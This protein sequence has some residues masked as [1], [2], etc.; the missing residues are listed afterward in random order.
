MKKYDV[1]IIGG[2]ITGLTA[3]FRLQRG[4]KSVLVVEKTDRVGGQIR[5]HSE[6]GFTFESGPNTSVLSN[7]EIVELFEDLSP[8]V[9]LQTANPAAQRRLIWKGR[10]FH[11]LPSGL[12]SAITTPLFTLS[13]KFR[14][15]GEPFR[16]K[17]DDPNE[18]VG[19]LAARRLGRSF[20]DYA[21]D[22]F[23][24]GIYAGDPYNLTTKYALPKLYNLENEYGG[25]V[26]GSL[27]KAK[28]PKSER[29]KKA[30]KKIFSARGGLQS[31]TDGLARKIGAE[32]IILS[33]Q[34]VEIREGFS[35]SYTLGAERKTVEAK[36]VVTTCGAYELDSLL[37]FV[38]SQSLLPITRL[39]YAPVVQV[40]VGVGCPDDK[41]LMAFGGLFP[42][43]EKRSVLGILFPSDCFDGRAP[44]GGKLYS[45]FIGGMR[46]P[47]MVNLP[48][49]RIEALVRGQMEELLGYDP[50]VKIDVLRV[51][52]YPKAIPQYRADS[53]ERF[54]AI[55]T[56]QRQYQGLILA[57]NIKGG[58]S[59]SDRVRQ[60]CDIAAEIL[61]Q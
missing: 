7:P 22:P 48:Q 12:L 17:G 2:G 3:A 31:I 55:E 56:L 29:E 21:V 50:C 37:P 54:E 58:I 30:T 40:S 27:A 5:S 28:L 32:N 16:R 43:K 25:F 26:R 60:G 41:L 33:A 11:P 9:E 4:G 36:S 51:F 44:Q 53:K 59:M 38:D 49:E 46:S 10:G 57:G 1:V 20:V 14:V 39:E 24:S 52:V 61:A 15:L 6:S 35:V 45:F 19:D 42:S 13:D 23:I 18:S 8:E 47:H 34:N